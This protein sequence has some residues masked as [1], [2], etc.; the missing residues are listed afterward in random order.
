MVGMALTD[1]SPFRLRGAGAEERLTAYSK[2]E[3]LI[4]PGGA[5]SLSWGKEEKKDRCACGKVPMRKKKT[6]PSFRTGKGGVKLYSLQKI[7]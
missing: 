7:D 6:A 3:G 5:P 2:G 1:G 4:I